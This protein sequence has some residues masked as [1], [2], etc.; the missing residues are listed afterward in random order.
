MAS[1]NFKVSETAHAE[2]SELKFLRLRSTHSNHTSPSG[3]L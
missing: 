1:N 3:I 2:P